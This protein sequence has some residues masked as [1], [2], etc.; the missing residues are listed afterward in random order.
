MVEG[1]NIK[2]KGMHIRNCIKTLNN[3]KDNFLPITPSPSLHILLHHTSLKNPI[4]FTHK[5]HLQYIMSE[6]KHGPFL[7]TK[8]IKF[9]M[10][11]LLHTRGIYIRKCKKMLDPKKSKCLFIQVFLAHREHPQLKI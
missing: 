6:N 2:I 4:Y 3:Y 1:V 5:E 7:V 8:D 9:F 11:L 10:P